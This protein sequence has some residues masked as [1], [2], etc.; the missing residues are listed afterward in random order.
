MVISVAVISYNARHHLEACLAS[1]QAENAM[2]VI[3]VD[4]G[5]TDG[6]IEMVQT[7]FPQFRLHVCDTNVGYGAAANTAVASSQAEYVLLLNSDTLLQSGALDDLCCYL[8]R[9]P[10]CGIVGPRMLNPDG[11][12]QPSC[13]SFPTPFNLLVRYTS[14]GILFW[15]LP[16]LKRRHLHGWDHSCSM[17]VPWVLGAAIVVR[18]E[19]FVAINGFDDSFFMYS[20]DVDLCYRMHRANWEVRYCP[21]AEVVH[22]REGSTAQYREAMQAQLYASRDRYYRMHYS[23]VQLL[24]IR[25]IVYYC[26]RRDRVLERFLHYFNRGRYGVRRSSP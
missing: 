7:R 19:A 21:R 25:M 22:V 18:R 11:S 15:R 26:R 20:E 1:I 17:V 3:V 4:N 2:D 23:G 9:H 14:L 13:Y 16:Y 5:S 24:C 10:R 6:S 12:L 8:D